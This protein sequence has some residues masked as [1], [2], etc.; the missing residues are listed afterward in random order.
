MGQRQR[1]RHIGRLNWEDGDCYVFA[2]CLRQLVVEWS[3]GAGV[4]NTLPTALADTPYL[5]PESRGADQH[6]PLFLIHKVED[7]LQLPSEQLGLLWN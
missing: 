4:N 3:A 2:V 5:Q 6:H 1:Q 7:S